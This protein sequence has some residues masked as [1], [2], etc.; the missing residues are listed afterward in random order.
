MSPSTTGVALSPIAPKIVHNVPW[1]DRHATE[2][3]VPQRQ[4]SQTAQPAHAPTDLRAGPWLNAAAA[5][6]RS[7]ARAISAVVNPPTARSVRTTWETVV[8]S[9]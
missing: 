2:S 6:S 1:R 8:S 5:T 7:N 3:P 9:G 4:T